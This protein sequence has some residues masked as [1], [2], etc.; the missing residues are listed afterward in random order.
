[1]KD[2]DKKIIKANKNVSKVDWIG[3]EHDYCV[4]IL[5]VRQIAEKHSTSTASLAQRVKK[6]K[7]E[8]NLSHKIN[9]RADGI[10]AQGL[11]AKN[12][13]TSLGVGVGIAIRKEGLLEAS[14]Q[15][16]AQVKQSHRVII[17]KLREITDRMI[18]AFDSE[19]FKELSGLERSRAVA[20][21]NTLSQA[22]KCQIGVERV[23]WNMDGNQQLAATGLSQ[24]SSE[25]LRAMKERIENQQCSITASETTRTIRFDDL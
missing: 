6:H 16:Q 17:E 11:L 10:V 23:A 1:M 21:I 19:N 20:D 7:W 13:I 25:L 2:E 22:V 24:E 5:T 15:A 12:T 3:V 8:R 18:S 4:G 9:T 14:A